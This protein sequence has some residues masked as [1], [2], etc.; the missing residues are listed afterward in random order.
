MIPLRS[1]KE[2]LA[3]GAL[4]LA[5]ALLPPGPSA[6][7]EV[8]ATPDGR[9]PY[10]ILGI[11]DESEPIGMS[12]LRYRPDSSGRIALNEQGFANGDGSPSILSN[13]FSGMPIVAWARNSGTGY[14]VVISFVVNGAWSVPEVLAGSPA[15][16]LDPQLV[17]DP[18]SGDVHLLFWVNDGSPR[19]L[20]R[21]APVDLSSWSDP[22][23]VSGPG[24]TACRPGGTFHDGVL[25]VAYEVHDWGF[26]QSPRQIVLSKRVQGEFVAEFVAITHY[27]GDPRP[28]AH[29][30]GGRLW[31]DWIDDEIAWIRKDPSGHWESLR[32][33]PYQGVEQR[34]F[35]VRPGIRIK[36]LG[37]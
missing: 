6:R 24:Q 30:Y 13:P 34:D 19:V 35:R 1:K 9:N 28:Q 2:A 12:W 18:T 29:S 31:V 11:G 20:H 14:D 4:V 36:A 22:V 15:D 7:A 3:A 33:E 25:H 23:Q 37:N 32:Y 8:G 10:I 5:V 21:Q 16:E 27:G 17:L 26:Q